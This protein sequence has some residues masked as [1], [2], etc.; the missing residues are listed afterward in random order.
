[1]I[2]TMRP[3]LRMRPWRCRACLTRCPDG[4]R[5]GR[6]T[7][8]RAL[9]GDFDV[10]LVFV[11]PV[12]SLDAPPSCIIVLLDLVIGPGMPRRRSSGLYK[13]E[14]RVSSRE[15]E[16]KGFTPLPLRWR[17]EATFGIS[18]NRH[19]HLTRNL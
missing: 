15:P 12:N 18:T 17:I 2:C 10:K 11:L 7:G 5:L 4:F 14:F 1:M 19:R 6:V 13:V 8:F 3:S 16:A 9:Y